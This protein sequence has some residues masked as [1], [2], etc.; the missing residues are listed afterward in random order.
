M[1]IN[2]QDF[3]LL[4]QKING[5]QL[6]YFDN[7]ATSQRPSAVIKSLKH[8]YENNNANVHRGI[9][10]LSERATYQYEASRDKVKGFINAKHRE[11]IIFTRGTT[12]SINWVAQSYGLANVKKG[13]EIVISI[14]EHHANILP[15]QRLAKQVGAKLKYIYLNDDFTLDM[16][17]AK[18]KITSATKIVA[19]TQA[20]NVLGVI[21]PIKTLSRLA[22]DN[23]AVIVVDGAQSVPH[24]LV[25]V[26]DLDADFFAFSAHKMMGPTGIGVLYGKRDLLE[27]MTPLELG[28][29]MIEYVTEQSATFQSLPWRFEAGT[30]NIA[31]AVGLGAAI[32]YI[33]LV[34]MSNISTYESELTKYA[35][36][37]LKVIKGIQIYGPRNEDQANIISFKLSG[38]HAHDVATALDQEGIA[39][40][41]GHHCAQPLMQYLNIKSTV[42]VSIASYNTKAE[43]DQ[44]VTVLKGIQDYFQYDFT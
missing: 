30:P 36:T 28:G 13:D 23:G 8:Y 25:N 34:G 10:S 31:G 44:L 4:N 17:D 24:M 22:H 20:S 3:P 42:R 2:R 16:V 41:A 27:T 43:I 40:R 15:W 7:A 38:V 29:E 9:Y 21:N 12:E 5:Q 37:K 11:E 19:I 33:Q 6:I 26:V 1:K 14:M 18:N 39:V 35:L 32:D